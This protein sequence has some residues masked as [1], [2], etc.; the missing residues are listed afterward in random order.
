MLRLKGGDPFIFGRGGEELATLADER[1]PFQVVPGVTAASGCA[2][3]AGIP[4]THR[5]HTRTPAPSSP[6]T[7]RTDAPP[8]TGPAVARP[9]QTVVVY[10]GLVGL[11]DICDGFVE[12]GLDAATPAA[13]V[14]QG[15]TERQRVIEGTLA[16]LA[17]RVDGA[18]VEPPTLVIVGEVVRLRDKLDWFRTDA[19]GAGA[20][21]RRA[22][23]TLAYTGSGAGR[24]PDSGSGSTHPAGDAGRK[25]PDST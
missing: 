10:M 18:G 4:L 17:G 21:P 2:A 16:T 8:S 24:G 1:I 19:P 11:R 15:T 9:G 7:S 12:H 14:E 6:E 13:L 3:Y 25:P 5:D 22:H 23:A 20:V